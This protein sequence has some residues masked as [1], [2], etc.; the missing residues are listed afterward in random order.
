MDDTLKAKMKITQHIFTSVT[1]PMNSYPCAEILKKIYSELYGFT[2]M[3]IRRGV[4]GKDVRML[5]LGK[6]RCTGLTRKVCQ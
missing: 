3:C 5:D 1:N 6:V 2:K 4:A